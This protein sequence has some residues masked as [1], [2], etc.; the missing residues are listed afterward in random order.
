MS[1]QTSEQSR[2]ALIDAEILRCKGEMALVEKEGGGLRGRAP[3]R[4]S[5]SRSEDRKSKR[6]VRFAGGTLKWNKRLELVGKLVM[7]I[8]KTGV[9]PRLYANI[10][11]HLSESITKLL[12]VKTENDD[13][14]EE[15]VEDLLDCRDFYVDKADTLSIV[16]IPQSPYHLFD[17]IAFGMNINADE[18]KELDSSDK[19]EK[20]LEQLLSNIGKKIEVLARKPGYFDR[21]ISKGSGVVFMHIAR[22]L[23]GGSVDGVSMDGVAV[24]GGDWRKALKEVLGKVRALDALV[25]D[26]LVKFVYDQVLSRLSAT[27]KQMTSMPADSLN[28]SQVWEKIYGK[29]KDKKDFF[30]MFSSMPP[31]GPM[32]T[33]IG[34]GLEDGI[35]SPDDWNRHP[36]DGRDLVMCKL[37]NQIGDNL[38]KLKPAAYGF[39]PEDGVSIMKD[40]AGILKNV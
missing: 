7:K 21:A 16:N 23:Q 9:A 38:G 24:G 36:A 4:R 25:E 22:A 40:I 27:I 1:H 3:R 20:W 29:L 18:A 31:V 30:L 17:A 14:W 26:R 2:L 10:V 15:V 5:R 33:A 6:D 13:A 32:F 37:L 11:R 35:G 28:D 8:N 19:R 39:L 12:K 34:T